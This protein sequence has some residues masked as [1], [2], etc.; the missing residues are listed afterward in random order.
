M[1][2]KTI[3]RILTILITL[4]IFSNSL[5][6]A[7]VSS[8]ESGRF[9]E[10]LNWLLALFGKS[11]D[12]GALQTVVRKT[13]HILEFTL[14][15]FLLFGCFS[16]NFRD[17]LIYVLFFGILTACTDEFLQLFCEGRSGQV[18]D[19]FIDFAGTCLGTCFDGAVSY[20]RRK[21]I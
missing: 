6:T 5:K 15:G 16:G 19:I 1:K 2:K 4:F 17:R 3:Y 20:I 21:I 14:Q 8:Q 10:I 7:Q 9:V 18:Q 13:A 11:V 12:S